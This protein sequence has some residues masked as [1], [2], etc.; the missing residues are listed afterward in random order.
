VVGTETFMELRVHKARYVY[1]GLTETVLGD[2][3]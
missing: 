2:G 3:T 1:P